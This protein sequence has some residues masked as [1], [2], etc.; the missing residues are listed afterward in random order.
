M[1]I[2]LVSFLIA[3][4]DQVLK[5]AVRATLDISQRIVVL[6]GVFNISHVRNTGAAWGL[7]GG[8][9]HWL[10]LFS[11]LMLAALVACRRQFAHSSRLNRVALSLMIGG[12]VGNLVDRIRLG[13][14]VDFL[15]FHW[16][17]HHFPSFNIADSAIC[18]GVGLYILA[19]F[20][21]RPRAAERGPGGAGP[22]AD[23]A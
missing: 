17:H 18:T 6:P 19:Q 7:F 14:V 2:L 20:L 3:L 23:A 4:V 12:I 10:T 22:E 13:Y 5:Y 8:S 11:A 1:L 21:G 16:E 9:N 15:D